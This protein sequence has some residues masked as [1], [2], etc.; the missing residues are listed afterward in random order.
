MAKEILI[1]TPIVAIN[2]DGSV[3]G[4]YDCIKQFGDMHHVDVSHLGDAIKKNRFF[5]GYKWMKES[6]YREKYMRGEDMSYK[7]PEIY[8][9]RGGIRKGMG[10]KFY[11]SLSKETRSRIIEASRK[12]ATE[13]NRKGQIGYPPKPV[14][15][16]T[17]GERFESVRQCAKHYGIKPATVYSEIINNHQNKRYGYRFKFAE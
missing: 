13:R 5:F 15:C 10:R 9:A 14:I 12:S 11:E 1:R 16:I 3:A 17:T 6:D 2:T 4:Y 8:Y 7:L